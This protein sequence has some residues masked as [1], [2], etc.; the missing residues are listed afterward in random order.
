MTMA[1]SRSASDFV[2]SE[3]SWYQERRARWKPEKVRLLLIAESA[4][5]DGGDL[6]NRRFFYDDNLTGRDSLF[7]EVVRVLFDNPVLKSGPGAKVPWLEK[8]RDQGVYLIDLASVPVNYH[9]KSERAAA[10]QQNIDATV[11]LAAG[12]QPGGV[13]L[14]K[15]NVFDLLNEPIRAAGLRMLYDEFIPFP[16]SGQ[17]GRFRER[18]SSAVKS[19]P[20][21]RSNH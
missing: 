7:R 10:L 16:A 9:S 8:L 12:L 21:S 20:T 3:D 13:V 18:F 4:P 5:D 17:Q 6:A 11:A 14:V 15:Q 2:V 19:L 1:I